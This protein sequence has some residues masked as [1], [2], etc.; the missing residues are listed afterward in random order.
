M[1]QMVP[2]VCTADPLT[3]MIFIVTG[4]ESVSREK[5]LSIRLNERER[6]A[7]AML[8]EMERLPVSSMVRRL[9]L[10]EVDRRC[11]WQPSQQGFNTREEEA[12]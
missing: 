3:K 12:G 10:Q 11:I 7:I 5:R 6:A 8:A 1:R 9:L 4:G 2:L